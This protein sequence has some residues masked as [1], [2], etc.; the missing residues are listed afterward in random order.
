MIV[1]TKCDKFNFTQDSD[2]VKR[3]L[4]TAAMVQAKYQQMNFYVHFTS[5]RT[6]LGVD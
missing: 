2:E 1:F 4:D 3:A 5:A 6:N